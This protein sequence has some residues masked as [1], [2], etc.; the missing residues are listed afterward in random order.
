MFMSRYWINQPSTLQP[1]HCF[2]GQLCIAPRDLT[3]LSYVTI[4]FTKGSVV[5]ARV[6]VLALSEGWPCQKWTMKNIIRIGNRLTSHQ[7]IIRLIIKMNNKK[8]FAVHLKNGFMHVSQLI[9]LTDIEMFKKKSWSWDI[10][11]E[12][13]S[14]F[15][16]GKV[17]G[18][19]Y[20][21]I[22]FCFMPNWSKDTI[23][24]DC[25]KCIETL[26]DAK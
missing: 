14:K 6:S 24:V 22:K 9:N 1:D 11:D 23:I 8:R 7:A 17:S 5:S 21:G 20:C 4:Y 26:H 3:N 25:H 12:C 2:H 18:E 19:T 10:I 15:S 13:K 16:L